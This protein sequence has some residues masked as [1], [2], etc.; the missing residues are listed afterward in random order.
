MVH[1]E[2]NA[3]ARLNLAGLVPLRWAAVLGQFLTIGVAQVAFHLSLPLLPLGV[4]LWITAASNVYLMLV[5]A[6]WPVV[7]DR[8][9]AGVLVLDTLQLTGLLYWTGGP[10][11][12]FSVLYLVHVA[13]SAVMLSPGWTWGLT[14]LST[15]AFGWLFLHSVPVPGLTMHHHGSDHFDL[16]LRGMLV[17]FTVAA[18]LVAYFV[19]RLSAGRRRLQQ[20]LARV[21]DLAVRNERLAALAT[22]AAGAAHELGSP[23]GT[24]AVAAAE[25]ERGCPPGED[26]WRADIR[27]IREEVQR[28]RQILDQ[29]SGRAGDPAGEAPQTHALPDWIEDLRRELPRGLAERLMVT[30]C[31]PEAADCLLTAPR[32][33]FLRCLRHLIQNGADASPEGPPLRLTTR[34]ADAKAVI[35][36]RDEGGGM[37]P[38]VLERAGEPF[39]TT[40]PPGRGMGL[41]LFLCRAV[42]DSLGGRLDLES[43][44]GHGTTARITLPAQRLPKSA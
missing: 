3:A 13:L 31:E 26:G 17:A 2:S 33:P 44:P 10:A 8:F 29:L 22:L 19:I 1:V 32:Q 36:I 24:I 25:L 27:L 37:T 7:D 6:R 12:P 41:G 43:R 38:D 18:M 20:E 11:N 9:T 28:C 16:H 15:G 5:L 23:L 42:L 39:F 14:A 35:Q 34:C 4:L 30:P 21:H 40:K